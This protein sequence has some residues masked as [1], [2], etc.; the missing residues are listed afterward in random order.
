MMSSHDLSTKRKQPGEEAYWEWLKQ[1]SIL[2]PL[3]LESSIQNLDSN[4]SSS[5]VGDEG[6]D[7]EVGMDDFL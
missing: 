3:R 2:F 6:S 7:I 4:T 1:P 5:H